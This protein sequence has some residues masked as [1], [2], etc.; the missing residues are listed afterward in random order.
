MRISQEAIDFINDDK[1][2][3]LLNDF[4][5]KELYKKLH[6]RFSDIYTGEFT[7]LMYEAGI[8]PLLYLNEIPEYFLYNDENVK[9]VEIPTNITSISHNAFRDSYG[10]TSVIIPDSV[11][12]IGSYAFKY[13]SRLISVTI[14]DSVTSIGGSAFYSCYS[15]TSVTIPD[16]VKSIS[17]ETFYGCSSLTSITIPDS[18]TS[19]DDGAF[20]CCSGLTHVTIGNGL[21][22]IGR[23]TFSNCYRLTSITY[24]GTIADW[25]SIDKGDGWNKNIPKT[26][27]IHCADGDISEK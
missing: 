11:T 27:V 6:E 25:H 1:N 8:D 10:L 9:N 21:T 16:D 22:V 15:L 23:W 14:P 19:I 5:F 4:K 3:R 17:N 13:C 24:K 12:F 26:Y 7:A 2:K 18:V 20:S